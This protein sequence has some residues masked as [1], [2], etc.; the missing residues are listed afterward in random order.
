MY[1]I[2]RSVTNKLGGV[3]ALVGAV[4]ILFLVPQL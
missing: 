1:A 3:V 2:L 4:L